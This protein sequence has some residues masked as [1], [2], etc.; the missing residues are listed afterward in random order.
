MHRL[1]KIARS[2]GW[3]TSGAAAAQVLKRSDFGHCDPLWRV[4]FPSAAKTP[5]ESGPTGICH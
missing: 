1:D 2:R 3:Q 5:A 4:I